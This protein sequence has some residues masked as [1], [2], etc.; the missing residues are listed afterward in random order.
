MTDRERLEQLEEAL[1][2][3]RAAYVELTNN[4]SFNCYG[5]AFYTVRGRMMD[6]LDELF[7]LVMNVNLSGG[8]E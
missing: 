2:K 5:E 8:F 1:K 6:S 7:D 3:A 4:V